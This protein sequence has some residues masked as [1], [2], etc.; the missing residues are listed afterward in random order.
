MRTTI[1]LLAFL[2]QIAFASAN[3]KSDSFPKA[4]TY[5]WVAPVGVL[6]VDVDAWGAG[7]GSAT[8][9]PAGTGGVGGGACYAGLRSFSV[10]PG[11]SYTVVVPAKSASTTLGGSAMFSA[12]TTLLAAGGNFGRGAAGGAQCPTA[13]STGDVKFNGGKGGNSAAGS[14]GCGGGS[15]GTQSPGFDGLSG[16]SCATTG[17]LG[18]A[19]GGAEGGTFTTVLEPGAGGGY[20]DLGGGAGR[21][22]INYE[23]P[24]VSKFNIIG[25]IFNVFLRMFIQ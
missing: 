13:S 19:F 7:G 21:V 3:I 18:G 9:A 10:T 24:I 15:G 17:G 5:T 12:S 25:G 4:G 22:V 14:A 6:R 20:T 16:A 8:T 11:N 23:A 2:S 1:I